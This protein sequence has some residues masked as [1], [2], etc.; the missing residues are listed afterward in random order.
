M[1]YN[2]QKPPHNP[3]VTGSNPFPA[4]KQFNG[5]PSGE[6]FVFDVRENNPKV[7]Y[8]NLSPQLRGHAAVQFGDSK[9]SAVTP[10]AA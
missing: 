6:P 3:K 2:D 7:T 8:L 1:F 4:T 5:L 9:R 10:E